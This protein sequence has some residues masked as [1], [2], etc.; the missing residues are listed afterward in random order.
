M[1]FGYIYLLFTTIPTIYG[2][3]YNFSEGSIGLTYLG[4]GVGALIGMAFF[5]ALSDRIQIR[6]TARNNG[7]SEPEFRLPPLIPGSTLIPI[8]LFWYGWS[9]E[10]HAHWIMPIIGI[11]WIGF[12]MIATFLPIQSY[13]VDAHGRYAASAVAAT[14]VF[15]SLVGA[16]LPLAGPSMFASLGY[17]WGNSL[18]GFIALLMLPVPLVF[19]Y[20]GKKIR[21][22]PRFQVFD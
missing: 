18:L 21:T 20:Y 10:R 17:G 6:L 7:E 1:V 12:G 22:N 2:D 9:A 13:L 11:G 19:F 5:G 14:T 15:R 4:V 16:F 8:G 3:I